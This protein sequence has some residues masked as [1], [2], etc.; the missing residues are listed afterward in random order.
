MEN[1]ANPVLTLEAEAP[2]MPTLTLDTEAV[3]PADAL[4][5]EAAKEQ[6]PVAV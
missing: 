5:A 4:S 6:P 3:T 1:Q 2:A